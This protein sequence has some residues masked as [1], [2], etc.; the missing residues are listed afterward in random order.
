M[1][2]KNTRKYQTR[3]GFKVVVDR[4]RM[5]G[6]RH[7][8]TGRILTPCHGWIDSSW[9]VQGAFLHKGKHLYDL[10]EVPKDA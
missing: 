7:C 5:K 2:I 4:K 8:V 9:T 10:V 3:E 1:I 6:C